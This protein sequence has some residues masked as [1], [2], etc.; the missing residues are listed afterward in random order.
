M[1]VA[2]MGTGGVGGYFGGRLATAGHEVWFIA[3]GVNLR[4]LRERGLKVSSIKG[5]FEISPVKATDDPSDIGGVDLAVV[6]VKTW[7][8]PEAAR[9]M[10]PLVGPRTVILPLLNGV[11]AAQELGNALTPERIV[12]G[13]CRIIAWLEEPGHIRH[14]GIEPTVVFGEFDGTRTDRVEWLGRLFASAGIEAEVPESISAAIWKKF[15]LISTWGGVGAITRAPLGVWRSI[16]GT[17]A[18]AKASMEETLALARA[19]GV[20]L[21][22]DIVAQTMD[23]I[24]GLPPDGTASMQRDIQ[25]GRPSE[26]E[27]MSGAVVRLASGVNVPAPTH[28]F[29]YHCLLPQEKA[30]RDLLSEPK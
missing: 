1:R 10:R 20:P 26:L 19:L 2:I 17:R 14:A 6:A 24:D 4:T 11:E 7:Q 12:G 15:M 22:R 3:R 21:V 27:S 5:D 8:L 13:L 9:Q 16:P 28:E 18:I 30:A 29:L 25:E 23:F